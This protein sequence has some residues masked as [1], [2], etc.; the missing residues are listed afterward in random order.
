M[1]DME[2]GKSLPFLLPLQ[3]AVLVTV[4]HSFVVLTATS[5]LLTCN[6]VQNSEG[7]RNGVQCNAR[8]GISLV[9]DFQ[10]VLPFDISSMEIIVDCETAAFFVRV[11]RWQRAARIVTRGGHVGFQFPM[12][13]RGPVRKT[14]CK[15][16]GGVTL[17][18]VSVSVSRVIGFEDDVIFGQYATMRRTVFDDRFHVFV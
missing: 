17:T 16:R 11:C 2:H 18:T 6:D 14:D 10:R 12:I 7:N 4:G 5:F 8:L 13:W 9:E 3:P 1:K 15:F